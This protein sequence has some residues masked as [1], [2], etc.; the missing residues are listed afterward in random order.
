MQRDFFFV[1]FLTELLET[2]GFEIIKAY[3][4]KEG[5]SKLKEEDIDVLFV[6]LVMPKIDGRQL[7]RIS[8]S[9]V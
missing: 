5:V 1:E 6:D 2:K 7:I 4:G 3:D 8:R 9:K